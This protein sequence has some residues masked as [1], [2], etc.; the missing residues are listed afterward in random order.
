MFVLPS[1][2]TALWMYTYK[3]VLV[4][5][6][7]TEKKERIKIRRILSALG[8]FL[9]T[10]VAAKTCVCFIICYDFYFQWYDSTNYR[11]H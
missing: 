10:K 8:T 3:I 9:P 4:I 1:C 2:H 11:V 5:E 6:I 7:A